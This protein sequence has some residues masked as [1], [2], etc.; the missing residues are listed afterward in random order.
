[1]GAGTKTGTTESTAGEPLRAGTSDISE[2]DGEAGP[3]TDVASTEPRRE[4]AADHA[5]APGDAGK[6]NSTADES[7]V[8]GRDDEVE[9]LR[10]RIR[11]RSEGRA[12]SLGRKPGCIHDYQRA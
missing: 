12:L 4:P 9:L 11:S 5:P 3:N 6:G 8:P 1:V 10:W 2:T 7:L